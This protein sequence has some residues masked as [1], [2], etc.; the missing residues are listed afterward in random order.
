MWTFVEHI[1]LRSRG[2]TIVIMQKNLNTFFT[3]KFF[4]PMFRE[5]T[6]VDYSVSWF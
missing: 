3:F 4:S 2:L 1:I 6:L 5:R